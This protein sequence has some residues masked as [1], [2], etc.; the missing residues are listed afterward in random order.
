MLAPRVRHTTP[1]MDDVLRNTIGT[2]FEKQRETKY[3]IVSEKSSVDKSFSL[4]DC[5]LKKYILILILHFRPLSAAVIK[6]RADTKTKT[7]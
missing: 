5:K 2:R 6:E 1:G 7:R 3:E 4:E